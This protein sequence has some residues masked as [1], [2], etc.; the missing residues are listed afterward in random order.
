[1]SER[2]RDH[3]KLTAPNCNDRGAGPTQPTQCLVMCACAFRAS[4]CTSRAIAAGVLG[5]V[6]M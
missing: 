1:M 2:V 6:G 3:V 5:T 4:S